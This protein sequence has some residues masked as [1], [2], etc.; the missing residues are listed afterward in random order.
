MQSLKIGE[1]YFYGLNGDL[2]I[3]NYPHLEEI[4]VKKGSLKNLNLLKISNSE[5]LKIIKIGYGDS[6]S[7]TLGACYSVN[8]LIIESI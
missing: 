4:I 2:V 5:Q 6:R 1:G 3:E 8:T 7:E